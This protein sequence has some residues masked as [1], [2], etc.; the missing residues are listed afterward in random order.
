ME[1]LSFYFSNEDNQSVYSGE[2]KFHQVERSGKYQRPRSFVSY[3]ESR[4]VTANGVG[5]SSAL[6]HLF[7]KCTNESLSSGKSC[8]LSQ[9]MPQQLPPEL[10]EGNIEYKR[11]LVNPSPNRFEHLVTQMKWRLNEGGGEAIYRLGV[12]DDGR[13]SGLEPKE[14]A[15]SLNTL[16]RMAKR[17]NATLHPLRERKVSM[18]NVDASSPVADDSTSHGFR[19]AVEFLVRQS[20]SNNRGEPSVCVAVLGGVDAGKSTLISVLTDGELDNGRGRAR[21]NLFRHLHEV[22]SGR[23]S[24]LSSELLGFD[25]SGTVTNYTRAD[26]RL[27]RASTD[28]VV[29]NSVQVLTLLDLAG[30]SKYQRTTLA[31]LSRCQPVGVLLVVSATTGLTSIGLE[32][33][34]L[35]HNLGLPLAVV[36]SKIDQ[37]DGEVNRLRQIKTVRRQLACRLNQTNFRLLI[38]ADSDCEAS[39]ESTYPDRSFSFPTVNTLPLFA[40]SAVTGEGLDELLLFLGRLA[41]ACR[42][43]S[44]SRIESNLGVVAVTNTKDHSNQATESHLAEE[45]FLRSATSSL[46]LSGAAAMHS[47]MRFEICE[48]FPNVPGVR[49]PVVFGMLHSGQLMDSHLAF[50]GPDVEGYFH[51]V[52]IVSLKHNRQPH[53]VVYA[54]QTAS[55]A[56]R[57]QASLSTPSSPS[58]KSDNLFLFENDEN[59]PNQVR[60]SQKQ[61]H[62]PTVIR[63]GMVLISHMSWSDWHGDPSDVPFKLTHKADSDRLIAVVWAFTLE[64]CCQLSV[65]NGLNASPPVKP[66]LPIPSQRVNVYAGC[67]AQAAI[68][69][70]TVMT[71]EKEDKAVEQDND[72]RGMNQSC[73]RLFIRFTRYPEYLEVGRPV[74]ITWVGCAKAVGR[75]HSLHDLVTPDTPCNSECKLQPGGQLTTSVSSPVPEKCAIFSP[76]SYTYSTVVDQLAFFLSE[77]EC[78]AYESRY[79]C[80]DAISSSLGDHHCGVRAESSQQCLSTATAATIILPDANLKHSADSENSQSCSQTTTKKLHTTSPASANSEQIKNVPSVSESKSTSRKKGRRRRR[81][82]RHR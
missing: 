67:V 63:R 47:T 33:A 56:I 26:G 69:V 48:V 25:A 9:D 75:V 21:L 54:G 28:E 19:K 15:Y 76:T 34:E 4:I 68:V 17:L 64:V 27:C 23:T 77:P 1:D 55:V 80:F 40:V 5:F 12:D 30:H 46:K 20:P 43:T 51:L 39:N 57:F 7:A 31:G 2:K 14:L 44:R 58:T 66:P 37:L 70:E 65:F 49:D 16:Q 74:I 29:Q 13:I 24:S 53:H 73:G 3:E 8:S 81:R 61:S 60:L 50:L 79:A 45:R 41:C 42:L 52:R 11:K 72:E 6:A 82:K 18:T 59:S 78:D 62:L 36:I 71:T 35:A 22:Q 32:H 38:P 10:E